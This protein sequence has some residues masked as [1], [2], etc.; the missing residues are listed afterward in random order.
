LIC[1][2]GLALSGA[3]A[4]TGS[5]SSHSAKI[6]I[7]MIPVTNSGMTLSDSPPSVITRSTARSRFSAAITPPRTARGTTRTNASAASL[8]EL[9]SASPTSVLTGTW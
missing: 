7:S 9:T 8:S 6:R 1:V 2:S 4:L 5:T 3:F